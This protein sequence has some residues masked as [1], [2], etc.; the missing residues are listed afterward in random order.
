MMEQ[1]LEPKSW[2]V[3]A[4]TIWRASSGRRSE[5]TVWLTADK[6]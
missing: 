3:M 1:I 4:T 5:A 6:V 2:A